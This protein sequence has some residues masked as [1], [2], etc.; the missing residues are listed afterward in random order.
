MHLVRLAALVPVK[1]FEDAKQRLAAVLGDEE[2]QRLARAT[3]TGV[4]RAVDGFHPHVVCDDDAVAAWAR[5]QGAAVIRDAGHG[6]NPAIDLAVALLAADGFDQVLVVHGDLPRPASLAALAT[7]ASA[8]TR[9]GIVIVPDR[10]RDGTNVL[11]MPTRCPLAAAY[12][13]GSFR[14]HLAAALA[15]ELPVSVVNDVDLA[16]DVDQPSDLVHP[17]V[18]SVLAGVL[19][20]DG[21]V[22]D[23]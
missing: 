20:P 7:A 8:A 2:R 1:A 4:V 5:S 18:R 17:R 3:A 9:P 12:G 15:A 11:V 10:R 23:R 13:P 14:R 22:T 16:L 6:L 21:T 19:G